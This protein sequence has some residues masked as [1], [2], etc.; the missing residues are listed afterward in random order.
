MRTIPAELTEM[1]LIAAYDINGRVVSHT[2]YD[3]DY[4]LMAWIDREIREMIERRNGNGRKSNKY[5]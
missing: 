4:G 2:L 1:E 5:T 3:E